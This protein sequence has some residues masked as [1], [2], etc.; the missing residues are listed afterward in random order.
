[1]IQLP[2]LSLCIPTNG[3]VE[4]VVPV[5]NSIY[6]QEI[7]DSLFEVVVC[8][9][10]TDSDLKSHI[11]P[12]Y[13]HGNFIYQTSD[14]KMFQN[15]ISCFKLARGNL[16]KFINHRML[17]EPGAIKYLL[18]FE[19]KYRESKPVCY[20]LNKTLPLSDETICNKFDDFVKTLSYYSSWSAGLCVWKDDFDK[21][22][23]DT[24][25]NKMFPH[26]TILFYIRDKKQYVIKNEKILSEIDDDAT[27]KGKY[28]LFNTF[29][30]EYPL[31]LNELILSN[32]ISQETYDGIIRQLTQFLE[33][34]YA[35]FVVAK[36]PCSYDLSSAE[37]YLKKLLNKK[38]FI[39]FILSSNFL[40]MKIRIRKFI[41]GKTRGKND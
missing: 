23:N 37:E 18:D 5:L 15:Q 31:L 29:A 33:V 12:F 6:S 20:F 13:I 1:M 21:I 2:R 22:P 27:K 10:G 30:V 35:D 39:R 14:A 25:Y 7:D 40:G 34:L 17:M 38:D 41:T 9:N 16:I 11:Q 28:N 3:I 8:D 24:Q 32:D 4:W 26:A 36:T 19:E